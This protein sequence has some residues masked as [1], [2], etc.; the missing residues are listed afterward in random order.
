MD[1]GANRRMVSAL[2]KLLREELHETRFS[3]AH[4]V[5]AAA[6]LL[7]G[8]RGG[9]M[10][11]TLEQTAETELDAGGVKA[12]HDAGAWKNELFQYELWVQPLPGG[13]ESARR[14]TQFERL[15]DDLGVLGDGHVA[16]ALGSL[17]NGP[18][19]SRICRDSPLEYIGIAKPADL[20]SYLVLDA[21]LASS[22][23]RLC[24]AQ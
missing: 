16:H 21:C 8:E 5:P 17:I 23:T 11:T 18:T 6:E 19:L 15:L 2:A 3:V 22:I 20:W 14:R 9:A 12:L 10:S 4:L 13:A 24:L 1:T 7:P